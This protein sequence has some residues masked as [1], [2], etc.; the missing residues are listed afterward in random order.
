[1]RT[2][3]SPAHLVAL[4]VVGLLPA[5][6]SAPL[7]EGGGLTSYAEM[8]PSDGL[9]TKS[10]IHLKKE[11]VLAAKTVSILP[12]VFPPAAAPKLSSQQ[13]EMVANAIGRG[14]C[15]SLSDRFKVVTPDEPADLVV[16]T[17]VTRATETNEVA[18]GVS[19]AASLGTSFI[20]FGA[21]VPVPIPRIPIGLGSL[22]IEA[23]AVDAEGRRQAA[24]LWARGAGAFFSSPKASKAS[25]AYDL[26]GAFGE[27][28]GSLLVKGKSPF[29]GVSIDVPSFQ[30]INSAMGLAPKYA[31]CE[32]F[33]RAPGVGGFVGGQLGLPPEWTDGGAKQR[34]AATTPA[35]A[36]VQ[37]QVSGRD[38]TTSAK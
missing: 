7:V 3:V 24:M 26:A 35:P 17:A 4:T 15:I 2:L 10:R 16:Q 28:F 5:C 27:D 19:A 20:D 25:D 18:A 23:E 32:R 21:P 9:A 12:T 29:Q 11:P 38:R 34:T 8:T 14:L 36:P 1:M 6:A 30:K 37:A 33:G 22:S 31:A 13:R